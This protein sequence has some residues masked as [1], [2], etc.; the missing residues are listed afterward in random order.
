MSQPV[1][2]TAALCG[3]GTTKAKAPTVPYTAEE[4]A[5]DAVACA[6]A[7]ASI[8]HIHVRDA[9]GGASM[10][11]Q[12]FMKAHAAAREAL[13][14]AGLDAVLNLSTGGNGSDELRVAHI[15]AIE[16]EMCSF[17]PGSINWG[18]DFVYLN[19]PALIE[20]LG[21]TTLKT[22]TKPEIEIFDTA[23]FENVA[24]AVKQGVLQA[25]CHFQF[26]LGIPGGMAGNLKNLSFLL[27]LM[28]TASTWSLTGIGKAHMP[29]MLA[30]L[31]AG[32]HGIRVG[33]EDNIWMSKGVPATNVL[34]VE[35]AVELSKLAGRSIA[36]AQEARAILG[37][38]EPN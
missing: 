14:K 8:I 15:E 18:Y 26:I 1:V 5:Q 25:P 21:K 23:M 27:D 10:D 34:L 4:L 37:I 35:R 11:T 24:H 29:M 12:L 28:P 19:S 31:A 7:G 38:K 13:N 33:L 30:G 3:N 32:A 17:N 22:K 20:R 6:K 36:T 2:I 9:A 16:P